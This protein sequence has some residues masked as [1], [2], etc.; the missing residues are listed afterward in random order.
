MPAD[1]DLESLALEFPGWRFTENYI[2]TAGDE[3][4]HLYARRL[5]DH[6]LVGA[7]NVELLREKIIREGDAPDQSKHQS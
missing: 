4:R 2:R 3:K 1:S 5:S 7:P 6:V